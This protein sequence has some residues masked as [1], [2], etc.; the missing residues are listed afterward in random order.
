MKEN[1]FGMLKKSI[2]DHTTIPNAIHNKMN[3][4]F[5][6]YIIVGGMPEV[7]AK[8]VQTKSYKDALMIQRRIVGDYLND[9]AKYAQ[10]SDRMKARECFQSIPLQ[11][12]KENKKFQYKLVKAGGL[13]RYYESSL[14]WLSDSRLILPLYRI[15]AIQK[16]I[17]AYKE[18]SIFKVYMADTGLLVSQ[19]D[20]AIIKE[21]LQGNL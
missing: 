12:A 15:K 5:K 3:D 1:I 21:L 19:F 16:P 8:Y 14:N 7:V 20:E 6:S 2:K 17:E 18:L 11:L 13:A 10:G 9:M 4:L